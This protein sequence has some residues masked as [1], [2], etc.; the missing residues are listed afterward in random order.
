ML[1]V[2]HCLLDVEEVLIPM[3]RAKANDS[4]ATTAIQER[5]R[6]SELG[7]SPSA[8]KTLKSPFSTNTSQYVFS[9]RNDFQAIFH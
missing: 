5:Q 4:L 7:H 8:A 9:G 2:N 3:M 1:A 6:I